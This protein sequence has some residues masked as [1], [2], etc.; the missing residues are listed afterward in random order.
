MSRRLVVIGGGGHGRVVL[1]ALRRGGVWEIAGVLER[2]GSPVSDVLGVPVI[3]TDADLSRIL[4]GGIDA[5]ALGVGSVG[6]SR[7]RERLSAAV[8]E[9]GFELPS[10]IHPDAC[11]SEFA[12]IGA[13]AYVGPGATVNAGARL[14]IGCIINTGAI[15][16]HDCRIGDFAHIAPGAVLS[17]DVTVGAGAHV[18]TGAAISHGVT[19]G[20]RAIVGVGSAVVAD[21]P[22]GVTAC[23]N[24]CKVLSRS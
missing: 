24:P 17:G 2:P 7:E 13:G 6:D 9:T 21:V 10:V 1:D 15:V 22:P 3:G 16:D 23:G 8:R 18:G 20:E 11:V 14:G 5:A 19:V 4:A 12:E